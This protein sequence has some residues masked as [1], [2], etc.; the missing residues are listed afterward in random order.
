[1]GG[2]KRKSRGD[3]LAE[4]SILVLLNEQE[5]RRRRDAARPGC[6]GSCGWI[7]RHGEFLLAWVSRKGGRGR[8]GRAAVSVDRDLGWGTEKPLLSRADR[9]GPGPLSG[10]ECDTPA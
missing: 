2:G 6:S 8:E 3:L 1:M 4:V 10:G 5:K 7:R 9:C